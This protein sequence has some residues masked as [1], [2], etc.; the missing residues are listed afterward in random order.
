MRTYKKGDFFHVP[1]KNILSGKPSELQCIYF[2]IISYS[3]DS[4]TCF[5]SRKTLAKNTGTNIKTVDKYIK[6]LEQLGLIRKETRINELG[7]KTSNMYYTDFVDEDTTP[8]TDLGA[9]H[10]PK[11]VQP[12]YTKIG[13][14]TQ[15]N[16][17]TQSNITIY[18]S[19]NEKNIVVH[20][21]LNDDIKKSIKYALK[22]YSLDEIL[23]AIDVFGVI[24]SDPNKYWWTHKWGLSLFLKKGLARFVGSE[25]SDYQKEH[26]KATAITLDLTTKK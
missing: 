15:S 13:A 11:T 24:L 17:L 1:N 9:T 2:W 23:K 5:P 16:L 7:G 12:P 14:L 18:N 19:W 25:A 8:C 4:G 20:K 3:D 10:I 22:N 26:S 21:V 6:E